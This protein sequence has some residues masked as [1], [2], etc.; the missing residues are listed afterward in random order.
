MDIDALFGCMTSVSC[1]VTQG[2][3]G[4][5]VGSL[6]FLVAAGLTLIFG[7]LGVINFAHGSLYM[8]GA[9]LGFTAY[10]MTGSYILAILSGAVGVAMFSMVFERWFMRKVYDADVLMQLLVCYAFILILDDS[11][12]IIWGARFKSMGMPTIFQEPPIFIAGGVIPV[13]YVVLMAVAAVIAL[14]LWF[15]L[16]RTRVGKTVRAAAQNP[17]MTSALGLNINRIYLG[18]FACGGLL[19]GLAGV[20]AAPIRSLAPGMG[21]SILIESFIVTVI[22]G[23]GSISGALIG[24]LVIGMIDAFGAIGFPSFTK[25]LMFFAMIVIL[26]L[27]PS[28][29][30]GRGN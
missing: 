17:I 6:L 3:A 15:V 9:Y 24:A 13:F 25:E 14:I 7:V 21:F 5:I 30:M 23:I 27:K 8:L 12:K 4:L 19:A 29:L 2:G 18:V 22:G 10:E 16:Q 20:L 11:V 26:I 1:I 28:G